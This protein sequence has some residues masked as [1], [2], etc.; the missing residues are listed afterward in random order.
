MGV[1]G[2]AQTLRSLAVCKGQPSVRSKVDLGAGW[3]F[4]GQSRRWATGRAAY[5]PSGTPEPNSSRRTPGSGAARERQELQRYLQRMDHTDM[6][7]VMGQDQPSGGPLT[8]H[9]RRSARSTDQANPD[10]MGDSVDLQRDFDV[11]AEAEP[12]QEQEQEQEFQ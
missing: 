6:K 5:C 7:D 10:T 4:D 11:A 2:S 8:L 9:F 12:A 1:D 3:R